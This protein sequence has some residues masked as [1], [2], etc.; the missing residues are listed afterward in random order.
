MMT[1]EAA[2]QEIDRVLRVSR[3]YQRNG[4]SGAPYDPEVLRRWYMAFAPLVT[5]KRK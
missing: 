1:P 4:E 3:A 2:L 5:E